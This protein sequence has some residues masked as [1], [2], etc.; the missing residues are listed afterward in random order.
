M[1]VQQRIPEGS[2]QSQVW[3][4]TP[5]SSL[6]RQMQQKNQQ[7]QIAEA[8]AAESQAASAVADIKAV[9]FAREKLNDFDYLIQNF[10]QVD[11]TT[12]IGSTQLNADALLGKD[13]RLSHDA[14]TPQILIYHTHSQEGYAD[15]VQVMHPCRSSVS[16]I[17]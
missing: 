5:E 4:R 2:R 17:I 1:Q 7:A 10:Y 6:Q 14:S 13:V 15:S 8:G 11:N 16:V 9:T 3:R 12:T